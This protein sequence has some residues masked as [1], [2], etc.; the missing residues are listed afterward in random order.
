[1]KLHILFFTAIAIS[2]TTLVGCAELQNDLGNIGKSA[3][4]SALQ[5][6]QVEA[7]QKVSEAVGKAFSF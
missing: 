4:D 1:M 6:A 3:K 5:R 7:S 2:S